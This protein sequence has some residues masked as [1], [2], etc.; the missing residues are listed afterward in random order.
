MNTT[1]APLDPN[2]FKNQ[3]VVPPKKKYNNQ[4]KR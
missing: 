4:I 1:R 3:S 2:R